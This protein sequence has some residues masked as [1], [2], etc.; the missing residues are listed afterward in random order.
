MAKASTS[1]IIG[2]IAMAILTG[3]PG[4]PRAEAQPSNTGDRAALARFKA[5]DRQA[6]LSLGP[7]ELAPSRAAGPL[8]AILDRSNDNT[9]T[10]ADGAPARHLLYRLGMRKMSRSQFT[11]QPMP[12]IV[13]ALDTDGDGRLS[14]A[15]LRPS[16]AGNAP[17]ATAAPPPAPPD[18]IERQPRPQP[19]W[20]F[21]GNRWVEL[22][23]TTP[24]CRMR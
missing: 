5:L 6:D 13:A 23:A 22:P 16:L 17:L 24:T 3:W 19:C 10:A 8:F 14:M 15:E 11:S 18:M 1:A 12:R 7:D 4:G 9:L 21:D 20:Y 2:A